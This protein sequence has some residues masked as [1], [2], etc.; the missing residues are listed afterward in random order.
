MS[1]NNSAI[2]SPVRDR[3]DYDIFISYSRKDKEFVRQLWE[4]LV[5]A[6]QD[7]WVDWDDIPPTADLRQEIYLGI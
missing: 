3:A 5:Q 1:A 7:V 4:T 6:S 2:S